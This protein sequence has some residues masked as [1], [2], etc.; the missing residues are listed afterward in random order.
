MYPGYTLVNG[1]RIDVEYEDRI[2]RITNNNNLTEMLENTSNGSVRL[3]STIKSYYR[4]LMLKDLDIAIDSLAIEILGHVYPGRLFDIISTMPLVPQF[5][6]DWAQ[7]LGDRTDVI[8]CGEDGMDDNRW[9]W[10]TLATFDDILILVSP[11]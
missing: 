10:D 7:G 3:A 1:Y 11:I 8:D 5:I 4:N 2:V 6:R 9:I